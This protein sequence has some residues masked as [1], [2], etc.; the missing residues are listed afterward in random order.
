MKKRQK[1]Y[2]NIKT[3]TTKMVKYL[4]A[5]VSI[6][7]SLDFLFS[8]VS[9]LETFRFPSELLSKEVY[10]PSGSAPPSL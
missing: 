10:L 6:S 1:K 9:F 3:K 8:S 2:K 4:L 7:I 5:S